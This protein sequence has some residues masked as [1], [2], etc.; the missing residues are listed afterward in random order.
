MPSNPY[1]PRTAQGDSTQSAFRNARSGGIGLFGD[2]L[3]GVGFNVS[4]PGEM[5]NTLGMGVNDQWA[6]SAQRNDAYMRGAMNTGALQ[7]NAL[8]QRQAQAAN[9]ARPAQ[10][11]LFQQM[12]AQRAGPSLANMQTQQALGQNLQG[13]LGAGGGRA[14]MLNAQNV[15]AGIAGDSGTAR[16]AEQ[17]GLSNAAFGQAGT[18]RGA[19]LASAQQVAGTMQGAQQQAVRQQQMYASL[20]R[21]LAEARARAALE[22]YKTLRALQLNQKNTNLGGTAKVAGAVATAAS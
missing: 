22:N 13:A 17:L 3:N 1:D 7:Y 18:T 6:N 19:D 11:A 21:Q 9:Q 14:A 16:L 5:M 20:G 8:G 10:E 15:G 4:D 2:L 12:Q